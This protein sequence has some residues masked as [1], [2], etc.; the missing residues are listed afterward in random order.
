MNLPIG[1]FRF[2]KNPFLNYQLNRWYSL[3]FTKKEDIEL[4]GSKVKTFSDYVKEFSL[5]SEKAIQESRLQNAAFYNRASEF[6][7]DPFSELKIPTYHKF[8]ELFDKAFST[9][10]FVRHS[11]PYKKSYLS[12]IR[13]PSLTTETKG[14]IIGC[15]GFD[16]FIEEFYCIWKFFAESG[17]EVIAFEGPGQGGSLRKYNLPFDHDWEKPTSA[18]LD[19]FK[20]ENA[21]ALG[22]SMGG[23]W[24]LRASAFEK[25]ITKVIAM[26]P[27]YDWLEMT[28]SF[29]RKLLS[30]MLPH[31][32]MMNFFIRLKMNIGTL[33][34]TINQ[35]LFIQN[36]KEP[37]DAVN[38]MLGMNKEHLNSHLVT[39][40]VLLLGGEGDAFQPPVLLK[41]QKD[42]LINAKSV[43]E[44]IFTREESAAE[45]CQIGNIGIAL[46]TMLS[47]IETGTVYK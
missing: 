19:Y 5:A 47:W 16:S 11:V 22:I 6:L 32:K 17:Y 31:T 26:P 24:I 7:I 33:K 2:H 20:I 4:I 40:D 25:R 12:C 36:K 14:T 39:Q 10:K 13:I 30:W 34:H 42:A 44:R 3:G 37:M 8:I 9:E 43:S 15:G 27:V 18:V 41:K 46:E 35:A 23:Y 28:N 29:N 1:Y 45:H 21:I 38:W